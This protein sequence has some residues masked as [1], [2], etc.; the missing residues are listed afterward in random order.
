MDRPAALQAPEQ[1]LFVFM[2]GKTSLE[3]FFL[4]III[5]IYSDHMSSLKSSSE[6]V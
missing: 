4:I 6:K 5:L 3:G 2:F 1:W